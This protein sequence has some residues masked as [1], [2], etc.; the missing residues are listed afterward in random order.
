ME[1]L[2]RPLLGDP[3]SS[4]RGPQQGV[5]GGGRGP[6]WGQSPPEQ[7]QVSGHSS[8]LSSAGGKACWDLRERSNNGMNHQRRE[9]EAFPQESLF[10]GGGEDCGGERT[11]GEG[12]PWGREDSAVGQELRLF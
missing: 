3:R 6:V 1:P 9:K 8:L 11:V 2:H 4:S 5:R 12:G 10:R 7:R